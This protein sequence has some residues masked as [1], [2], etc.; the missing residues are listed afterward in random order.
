MIQHIAGQW[1]MKKCTLNKKELK[2]G[3]DYK[4]KDVNTLEFEIKLPARTE[5]GPATKE[6]TMHYNRRNIR[7]GVNVR[8]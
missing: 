8:L 1:D 4:K 2:L 3:V 5:A 6:L 7:P